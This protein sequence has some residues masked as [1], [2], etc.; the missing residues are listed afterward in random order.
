[1]PSSV[2]G[3]LPPGFPRITGPAPFQ[4]SS[5]GKGSG[6][7]VILLVLVGLAVLAGLGVAGVVATRAGDDSQDVAGETSSTITT[8]STVTAALSTTATVGSIA[9]SRTARGTATV[10]IDCP[11]EIVLGAKIFCTITSVG[12]TSGEWNLPGFLTAAEPIKTVP[13]HDQIYIE[14]TNAQVVGSTF[15][16]TATVRDGAGVA[17]TTEHRFTVV[18]P[19]V[20]ISCPETIA[21]NTS[22]ICDIV[23]TNAIE[24]EWDLP[25]FGGAALDTVPGSNPI[26][27]APSVPSA[28]G[29]TFT[30]TA[31]V[32]DAN[33]A[34]ATATDT[35]V[36]S[37][38]GG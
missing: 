31:T 35:F 36:V 27:I 14:P 5:P 37:A 19:G 17:S 24:G 20:T 7:R 33:G 12:A 11:P 15:V 8:S 23:S 1:M 29:R 32:R 9:S 13:G 28:V 21:I 22:I 18:G 2:G 6:G 30:I 26:S 3:G 16:I 34:S 10:A 4:P 25:D 38:A